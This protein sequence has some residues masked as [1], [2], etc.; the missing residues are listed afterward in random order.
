MEVK[1]LMIDL[2]CLCYMKE[3]IEQIEVHI[4]QW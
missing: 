4:S 2:S 1:Q 3:S